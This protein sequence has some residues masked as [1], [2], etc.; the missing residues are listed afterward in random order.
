MAA[1]IPPPPRGRKERKGAVARRG[2]DA[3][4]ASAPRFRL[5]FEK[6][7]TLTEG[8]MRTFTTADG[9]RWSVWLDGTAAPRGSGSGIG[10][11][12]LIFA[13]EDPP[14]QRIAYR[15]VGWLAAAADTD[16]R[17]ALLEGDSVRAAWAPGPLG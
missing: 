16:L 10:W 3:T 5:V 13:A 1:K 7:D 8:A 9:R 2:H 14:V 11:E 15:P 17:E 6:T 4:L 12:A